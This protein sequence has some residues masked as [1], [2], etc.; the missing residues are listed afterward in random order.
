MEPIRKCLRQVTLDR[1]TSS[2]CTKDDP[3]TEPLW[4]ELV[5]AH[6]HVFMQFKKAVTPH[7]KYLSCQN[8]QSSSQGVAIPATLQSCL[9]NLPISYIWHN[10]ILHL[11]FSSEICLLAS[12]N[13]HCWCSL[14]QW[15]FLIYYW[16]CSL[17]LECL[18]LQPSCSIHSHVFQILLTCQEVHVHQRTLLCHTHF[19][20]VSKTLILQ[21]A[22]FCSNSPQQISQGM[23]PITCFSFLSLSHL[24]IPTFQTF[25]VLLSLLWWLMVSSVNCC[26]ILVPH[27]LHS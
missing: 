17:T 8:H 16:V 21:M 19:Y 24:V 2:Q 13:P 25:S 1:D 20:C 5:P 12:G 7:S 6:M 14:Y 4:R 27:G 10:H 23:F 22:G 26:N 18:W 11:E 9:P 3:N 15:W